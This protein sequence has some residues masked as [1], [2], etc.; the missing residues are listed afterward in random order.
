MRFCQ[1]KQLAFTRS[2]PYRKND[3]CFV[4]QKNWTVVRK[5]V[6]YFRYDTEEELRILNRIYGY[7]RLYTNYF[8]PSMRLV[9]KTRNGAK[10]KKKYDTP[11]TPYRRLME[12]PAIGRKSKAAMKA[13]YETL[14]PVQLKRKIIKLQGRL[15]TFNANKMNEARKE[16]KPQTVSRTFFVRQR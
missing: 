9:S 12:N 1:E 7:L 8:Q 14:N 10:V 4:E 5:T 11:K 2:R 13:E 15:F 3:N 16:E 6:G